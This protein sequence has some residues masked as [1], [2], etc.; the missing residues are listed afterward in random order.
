M[1]YTLIVLTMTLLLGLAVVGFIFNDFGF[2]LAFLI[3]FLVYGIMLLCLRRQIRMG[4]IFIKVAAKFITEKWGVFVSPV[5][6]VIL[7]IG[8]GAF[9]IFSINSI[10]AVADDK[11][12]KGENNNLEQVLFYLWFLVWLFFGFFLYYIMVFTI[13]VACSFWYYRVGGK[14]FLFTSCKWI[15]TSAFGSIVFA[16]FLVAIITFVRMLVDNSR[17]RESRNIPAAICLCLISCCLSTIEALIK[18]LNHNCVIVMA[19][20]G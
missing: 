3:I 12:K 15:F 14:N 5:I 6:T 4:I 13:A 18:I 9:W 8:I 2:S 10:I 17:R 16:S 7:H 20:T 19:V 1:V 11:S